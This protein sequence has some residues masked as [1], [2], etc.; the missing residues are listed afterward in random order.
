VISMALILMYVCKK[1]QLNASI[2]FALWHFLVG[3]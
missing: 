1:Y 2:I 3:I